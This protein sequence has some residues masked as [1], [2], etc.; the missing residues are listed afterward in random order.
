MKVKLN[1]NK[2]NLNNLILN[3]NYIPNKANP[4]KPTQNLTSCRN[5][6]SNKR[7]DPFSKSTNTNDA[8]SSS[9][10]TTAGALPIYHALLLNASK[11]VL[12]TCIIN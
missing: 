4:D 3:T 12:L 8:I 6:S 2:N 9:S 11:Q 1:D 10:S 7:K 5:P